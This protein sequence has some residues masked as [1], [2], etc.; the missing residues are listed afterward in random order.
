MNNWQKTVD[1]DGFFVENGNYFS[2][3]LKKSNFVFSKKMYNR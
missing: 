1:L 2:L 3:L